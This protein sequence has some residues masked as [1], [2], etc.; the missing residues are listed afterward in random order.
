MFVKLSPNMEA[1]TMVWEVSPIMFPSGTSMGRS[2]NA[3]VEALPTAN[4]ISM[5]M[6]R[7]TRMA[8]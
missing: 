5:V 3:L 7:I 6:P 2:R 4:S 8:R 1:C